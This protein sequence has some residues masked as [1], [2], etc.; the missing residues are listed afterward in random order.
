MVDINS[1]IFAYGQV[2]CDIVGV[3]VK[4]D[5][6]IEDGRPQSEAHENQTAHQ[7]SVL[8]KPLRK[9]CNL[10]VETMHLISITDLLLLNCFR[11]NLNQCIKEHR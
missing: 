1:H 8:R 11:D 2:W 10:F 6:L 9:K 5:D 4:S 7:P 3:E